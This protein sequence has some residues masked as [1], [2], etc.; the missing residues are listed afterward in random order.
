MKLNI[1][2]LCENIRYSKII[3]ETIRKIGHTP[4][5]F[6]SR[7]EFWRENELKP[8]HLSVVFVSELVHRPEQNL[9]DHPA[10][11]KNIMNYVFFSDRESLSLLKGAFEYFCY[12]TFI[13]EN[14]GLVE[15]FQEYIQKCK[16]N[17]RYERENLKLK[18]Q[19]YDLQGKIQSLA[20]S[21]QGNIRADQ[22]NQILKNTV[23]NISNKMTK[24]DFFEAFCEEMES[25][26]FVESYSFV[27]PTLD[28][29]KVVSPY[30]SGFK[31]KVLPSVF[32][33]GEKCKSGIESI[34]TSLS[35]QMACDFFERKFVT[36]SLRLNPR[37]KSYALVYIQTSQEMINDFD[38]DLFSSQLSGFYAKSLL[39]R[40]RHQ[41]TDQN[42]H[43]PWGLMSLMQEESKTLSKY[44]V[45]FLDLSNL[46]NAAERNPAA[47]FQWGVFEDHFK[48]ALHARLDFKY[49]A[50][51]F[52]DSGFMY[53][54]PEEHSEVFES[55]LSKH[56]K[57]F[58]YWRYFENSDLILAETLTPRIKV[59]TS[60]LETVKRFIS[61]QQFRNLERAHELKGRRSNLISGR[62]SSF[63][64][65]E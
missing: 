19:V 54:I 44:R 18:K 39:E 32:V 59:L 42:Y 65:S 29:N 14:G 5:V 50:A 24:K 21:K 26:D 23:K 34:G 22:F 13:I 30:F 16:L 8:S 9:F 64:L 53:L 41:V 7:E 3:S 40:V 28:G 15:K 38:W 47:G 55:H 57:G 1:S 20:E 11:R 61:D 45:F 63:L 10:Y 46:I 52:E 36:L 27:E 35:Y 25:S 33:G 56:S 2:I 60:H 48:A 51:L 17:H 6:E 49:D 12:G 58:S 37:D 4:Y 31:Y 62:N 43:S